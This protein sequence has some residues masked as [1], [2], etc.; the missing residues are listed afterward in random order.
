[1]PVNR[2]STFGSG[3]VS[4]INKTSQVLTSANSAVRAA[5]VVR[6]GFQNSQNLASFLRSS[7]L[8]TAGEAIGDLFSAVAAF[9]GDADPNDWRVRLSLPLWPSFRTSPVLRPLQDAG[10]LIFPYTPKITMK[11][12]ATYSAQQGIHTNYPYRVYKNSTPGTIEIT[13]P[14]NVED[15]TQALYWIAAVHY[16]RSLTKMFTGSDPKAGNPPPIV[17]LNG[18]G[19]YVFR[20]IP[21]VAT[22]FSCNLEND[23]DYIGVNV[24]GSMAGAIAD[25]ADSLGGLTDTI[26]G[27]VGGVPELRSLAS[28]T[29][30]I[31][32]ALGAVS[33]VANLAGTFGLGGS[34]PAGFAY[35]P[36]KSSISLTLEAT[37][38]RNSSRTFSLDRFVTGGYVSGIFGYI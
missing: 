1:M 13:A 33:S 3:A 4:T 9:G 18:Y 10:G 5:Q 38:S 11:S 28:N 21:V 23:C 25:I 7:S 29:S 8:P 26:G 15:P 35:V 2:N 17:Y 12:S 27:L 24:V 19:Q 37:Y 36:T 34:T 14:M 31:S 20:N 32:N 30:G 6:S 22:Q 16:L